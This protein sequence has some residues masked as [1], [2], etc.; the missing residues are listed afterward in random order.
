MPRRPIRELADGIRY[1]ATTTETPELDR[2]IL[3]GIDALRQAVRGGQAT[4]GA[5]DIQPGI[6]M[7]LGAIREREIRAQSARRA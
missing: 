4:A 2:R 3:D 1:A 5:A 6:R 7:L